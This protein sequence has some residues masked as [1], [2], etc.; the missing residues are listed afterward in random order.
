M[1][2]Y[3]GSRFSLRTGGRVRGFTRGSTRG[4]RGPKKLLRFLCFKLILYRHLAW[5][6]GKGKD[7]YTVL[8]G[9]DSH[10]RNRLLPAV[11]TGLRSM[12]WSSVRWWCKVAVRAQN[13]LNS[14]SREIFFSR[15]RSSGHH[16]EHWY[17]TYSVWNTIGNIF[18][19]SKVQHYDVDGWWAVRKWPGLSG[20]ALMV[21]VTQDKPVTNRTPASRGWIWPLVRIKRT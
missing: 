16:I 8:T 15:Q 10:D 18:C 9:L 1:P 19:E 21:R 14:N 7:S 2:V 11:R 12:V 3:I 13:S 6:W 4:P 20:A 17:S 5:Y